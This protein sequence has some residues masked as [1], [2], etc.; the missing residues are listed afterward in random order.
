MVELSGPWLVLVALVPGIVALA[1]RSLLTGR[2]GRRVVLGMSWL[3]LLLSGLVAWEFHQRGEGAFLVDPLDPGRLFL[4]RPLVVVDELNSL[5]LPFGGLLFAFVLLGAPRAERA[6]ASVRRILAAESIILGTFATIEPFLLAFLWA[7]STLNAYLELR[8]RETSRSTARAVGIY[9][10]GSVLLFSLGILLLGSVAA[11]SGVNYLLVA[12]VL[13]RK[14]VFPFHSWVIPLFEHLPL[15]AAILFAAPQIAAYAAVRLILPTASPTLLSLIGLASL[16]TAIYG[17]ALALVQEDV[18][19]VLGAFFM[20]QS[21]LVM[22][23]L[24]SRNTM[25]LAGGLALWISTGLALAGFTLTIAAL[26][27]RRGPLSLSRF[28]GGYERTSF[29]AVS[30]L[31]LGLASV[32]FPGTLGFAGQEAL[33]H[34]AFTETPFRGA[35]VLLASA[36]NGITVMRCYLQLF[37][38]ARTESARAQ[39]VRPRERLSFLVLVLILFLGGLFPQP[40]LRSRERAAEFSFDERERRASE[41]VLGRSP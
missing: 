27:A 23:G 17:A 9:M 7:M 5:L 41:R 37:C 12:A 8:S 24:D 33:A 3:E 11:T 26:E 19:R 2:A 39:G 22:A 10:A 34:G 4:G 21:A 38:G 18:R 32:G 15:G 31:F 29:L 14:G 13:T 35:L 25:G 36:L 40:F 28:A 30:F 16:A 20:S 1:P 6:K